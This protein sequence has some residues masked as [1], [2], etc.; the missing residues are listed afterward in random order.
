MYRKKTKNIH[1]GVFN[2]HIFFFKID[3]SLINF[4]V[5]FP[6]KS[7]K[8]GSQFLNFNL[9]KPYDLSF[10]RIQNRNLSL[11]VARKSSGDQ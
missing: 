3:F 4:K 6:Y 10:W 8:Y 1:S 9:S 2:K 5:G 11:E 7:I